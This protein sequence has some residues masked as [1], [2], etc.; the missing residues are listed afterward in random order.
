[1]QL[2]VEAMTSAV[3]RKWIDLDEAERAALNYAFSD[4]ILHTLESRGVSSLV[5]APSTRR[6]SRALVPDR[7]RNI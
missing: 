6:C 1:M 2:G 4:S 3:A 5:S 7:T